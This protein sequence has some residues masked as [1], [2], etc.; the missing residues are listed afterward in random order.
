MYFLA[1]RYAMDLILKKR[2]TD[3][4]EIRNFFEEENTKWGLACI[5]H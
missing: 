2:S 5:N 1:M 4:N 3:E